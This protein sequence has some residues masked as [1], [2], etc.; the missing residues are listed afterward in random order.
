VCDGREAIPRN[1]AA[2]DRKGCIMTVGELKKKLAAMDD[3]TPVTVSLD[4]EEGID[5]FEIDEVA[6]H[7]GDPRRHPDTRKAGFR[8]S[9]DGPAKWAFISIVEA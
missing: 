7:I 5:L 4:T 2:G 9:G 8:F 1:T 6:I 3:K